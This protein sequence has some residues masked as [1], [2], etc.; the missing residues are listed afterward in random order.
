M[1]PQS[2]KQKVSQ[3]NSFTKSQTKGFTNQQFHKV[4][5]KRFTNQQF[6]KVTNKRFHKSTVSQSHKQKVSQINSFTKS[7]TE[8]ISIHPVVLVIFLNKFCEN[9]HG[10]IALFRFDLLLNLRTPE[11]S[12]TVYRLIDRR[13]KTDV[14]PQII[15][16]RQMRWSSE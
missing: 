14:I 2:H 6:H 15:A 1:H 12:I 9:L 3:I 4:T 7:Q 13:R 11:H 16:R 10:I 5:N 8:G